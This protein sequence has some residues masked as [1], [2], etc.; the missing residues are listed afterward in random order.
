M[1]RQPRFLLC[2]FQN[3]LGGRAMVL[4]LCTWCHSVCGHFSAAALGQSAFRHFSLD[5]SAS[6]AGQL[7]P[8][9]MA[10]F[11]EWQNEALSRREK[12]GQQGVNRGT[13]QYEENWLMVLRA[14]KNTHD[15]SR[16]SW[17]GEAENSKLAWICQ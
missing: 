4:H 14:L 6:V 5:S 16:S 8:H 17:T 10:C 11:F 1:P 2:P 12:R 9:N 13:H 3:S 15:D 7:S